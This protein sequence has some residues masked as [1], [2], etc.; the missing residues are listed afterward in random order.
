M[1][2][3]N[4][5]DKFQQLGRNMTLKV[6]SLPSYLDSFPEYLGSFNDEQGEMF[7]PEEN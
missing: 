7:Q 3:E 6:H 5:L 4:V 2:A 1:I